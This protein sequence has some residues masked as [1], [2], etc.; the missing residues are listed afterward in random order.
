VTEAQPADRRQAEYFRRVLHKR[1]IELG[2]NIAKNQ[3]LVIRH[4]NRS[5]S[6]EARRKRRM[7]RD[8]ERERHTVRRLID[9]L[10]ARFGALGGGAG[11]GLPL[12]TVSPR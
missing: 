10:E 11:T 3:L 9:A 1:Y 12:V 8:A 7:L 5:E 6:A 4:Q 2:D